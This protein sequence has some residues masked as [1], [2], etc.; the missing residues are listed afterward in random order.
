MLSVII[1]AKDEAHNLHRCLN[2]V[3]W[4]N[5]II[6][7]DSG[8]SDNTVVIAKEYTDKVYVTDWQG[9]GIQKQ[10]ALE[11][12]TNRWVL[13]LD[14]DES[15]NDSLKNEIQTCI[16]QNG[17]DGYQI[18]INLHFYGKTL[19][20]SCSP[21]HHIRL[22]KRQGASYSP[23]IVHEKILLPAKA[24]IGHLTTPI[25]HHCFQN[26]SHA[27]HKI[28]LYSTYSAKMRTDTNY[29]PGVIRALLSSMWMFFRCYFIQCGFLEGRDGFI[30]AFL[31]AQGSFYRWIKMLYDAREKNFNS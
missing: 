11:L 6:V 13:N 8:S 19:R 17:I 7:L 24:K 28:N 16:N 21:K 9:Y 18:P 1:I 31:C 4:A 30:L 5:E 22:F 3:S 27:V 14:A 26:L 12:T 29:S 20:Y 10:R 25:Q 23:N 2:S 15:I